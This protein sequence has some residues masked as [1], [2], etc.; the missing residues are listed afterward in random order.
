VRA[1]MKE[2]EALRIDGVPALYVDGERINGV[3][4]QTQLWMVIDRDLR[5]AGVEPPAAVAPAAVS[6]TVWPSQVKPAAA[7]Q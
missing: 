5:A 2:A 1:S 3:I 4:P 6:T 7:V